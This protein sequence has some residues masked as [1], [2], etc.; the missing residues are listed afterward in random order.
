MASVSSENELE[1][2]TCEQKQSPP[3]SEAS[4]SSEDE[5]DEAL[6]RVFNYEE[7]RLQRI[8]HAREHTYRWGYMEDLRR[9][10]ER[11][12]YDELVETEGRHRSGSDILDQMYAEIRAFGEPGTE[13]WCT[14][15][16]TALAQ[17]RLRRE[18]RARQ[19]EAIFMPVTEAVDQ[20]LEWDTS[21]SSGEDEDGGELLCCS[22]QCE[23]PRK[24]GVCPEMGVEMRACSEECYREASVDRRLLARYQQEYRELRRDVLEETHGG[25]R[26]MQMM[27]K[28]SQEIRQ[29]SN[30]PNWRVKA[31]QM[32]A[33]LRLNANMSARSA[34]VVDLCDEACAAARR[35]EF[36]RKRRTEVLNGAEEAARVAAEEAIRRDRDATDDEKQAWGELCCLSPS[37]TLLSAEELRFAMLNAAAAGAEAAAAAEMAVAAALDAH[38]EAVVDEIWSEASERERNALVDH[39]S[40]KSAKVL[41]EDTRVMDGL[42]AAQLQK[43]EALHEAARVAAEVVASDELLAAELQRMEMLKPDSQNRVSELDAEYPALG[44]TVDVTKVELALGRRQLAGLVRERRDGCDSMKVVV[45]A[46]T[47]EGRVEASARSRKRDVAMGYHRTTQ[48]G[49]VANH[50]Q[51]AEGRNRVPPPPDLPVPLPPVRPEPVVDKKALRKQKRQRRRGVPEELIVAEARRDEEKRAARAECEVVPKV[52][53]V[54]RWLAHRLPAEVCSHIVEYA[55]SGWIG[56]DFVRKFSKAYKDE[57]LRKM[58]TEKGSGGSN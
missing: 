9:D 49:S 27:T 43:M 19:L 25:M 3:S 8:Q 16:E 42:L 6:L 4:M 40:L 28:I 54:E 37:E 2:E 13:D 53:E 57:Q 48:Q 35:A 45:K 39:Q 21:D 58:H 56:D 1:E 44:M 12:H 31:A 7:R 34:D 23:L 47:D 20:A 29:W 26:G 36:H 18:T 52:A 51:V 46:D 33:A 30:D 22:E 38:A 10:Y 17:N 32:V 15:A 11:A 24:E 5:Q 14:S 41:D 50:G 55:E